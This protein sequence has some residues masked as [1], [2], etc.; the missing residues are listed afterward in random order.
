MT[1][2]NPEQPEN[3]PLDPAIAQLIASAT[4]IRPHE[5]ESQVYRHPQ[6]NN[7]FWRGIDWVGGFAA[8]LGGLITVIA[9]GVGVIGG[10]DYAW[11][12][13][14]YLFSLILFVI[15]IPAFLRKERREREA[16][17]LQARA[18]QNR[19]KVEIAQMLLNQKGGNN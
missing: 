9:F 1:A 16:R 6:P 4:D 18:D 19:L 14:F 17:Y 8:P 12:T 3:A 5:Q 11:V 10:P 2:N 13:F 7:A 15:F